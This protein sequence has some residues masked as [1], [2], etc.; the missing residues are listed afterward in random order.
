MATR[1]GLGGGATEDIGNHILGVDWVEEEP[2]EDGTHLEGEEREVE[3]LKVDEGCDFGLI[4]IGFPCV[5]ASMTFQFGC[6]LHLMIYTLFCE[7]RSP[8]IFW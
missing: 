4:I 6:I 5:I 2:S 1:Q 7:H 3:S 8:Q